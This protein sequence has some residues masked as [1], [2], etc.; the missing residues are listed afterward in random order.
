M[1]EAQGGVTR[2]GTRSVQN[3]RDAIGRH[4]ELSR[5]LSRT[6][7]E[8]SELFGQVLTRMDSSNCHSDAP[9]DSRQSQRLTA[10]ALG[11][12]TRSKSAIDR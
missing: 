9:S 1:S 3:L 8:C 2:D 5:Q 11:Q 6:H 10:P 4:M 7:I 12:P